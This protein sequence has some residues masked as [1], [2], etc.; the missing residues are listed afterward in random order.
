[1]AQDTENWL[2]HQ[3]VDREVASL[4]E[5]NRVLAHVVAQ[6]STP[7]NVEDLAR[8][9]CLSKQTVRRAMNAPEFVQILR[10]QLS[11]RVLGLFGAS[12]ERIGSIIAKEE[13]QTK[14]FLNA[15]GKLDGLYKTLNQYEAVHSDRAAEEAANELLRTLN[16]LP[17]AQATVRNSDEGK[18]ES[19][20]GLPTQP[21]DPD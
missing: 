1:M 10:Q 14:D 8:A 12:L 9:S 7:L 5:A 13:G 19:H 16:S 4:A 17:E 2:A 21:Q 6:G 18:R 15:V 11:R 3:G 20:L